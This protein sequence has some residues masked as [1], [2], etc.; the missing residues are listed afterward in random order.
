MNRKIVHLVSS[1]AT[2]GVTATIRLVAMGLRD[3]GWEAVLVHYGQQDGIV[4]ELHNEGISVHQIKVPLLTYG[5]IRTQWIVSRLKKVLRKIDPCLVN[6]HSFD[7]DLLAARALPPREPPIIVTSHSFSYV[8]WVKS[9]LKDYVRWGKR[10]SLLVPVCE[11][12][13][14]DILKIPAM[15]DMK[16]RVIFNVPDKR[17]LIPIVISERNKNR[18]LYGLNPTDVVIVSVANFHPLKG[19]DILA[20]AFKILVVN[21]PDLRLLMA[22]SAGPDPD[23]QLFQ[24]SIRKTLKDEMSRGQALIIDPCYD[25][26]LVLSAADV[27]V[28]PSYTEAL[29][30][31]IGE[32]LAC[33][34][35]VVATAV[36]GNPEIVIDGRTGLIVPPA[37]PQSMAIAIEKLINDS[38]LRRRLGETAKT[39]A[40][41]HLSSSSLLT[42]YDRVYEDAITQ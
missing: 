40:L 25:A 14:N 33:G 3:Q 38:A 30:V 23:R 16:M 9:H 4:S 32:A 31:A 8:Q 18:A 13:G 41:E 35:P 26:R 11:S 15:S 29:S 22:G 7:A 6:A 24:S 10:F 42:A 28:Q 1:P 27:Y 17:F 12:L 21:N 36:G 19:H 20:Q 2:S 39:F 5:P 34:L 37:N